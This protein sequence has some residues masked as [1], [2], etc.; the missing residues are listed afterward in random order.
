MLTNMAWLLAGLLLLVLGAEFFVRGSAGLARRLGLSELFIGLTIVAFG[1]SSPELLVSAQAA[2]EG[3]PGI[4]LG[5]IVGS[6]IFNILAILGISGLI[7]PLA[8]HYRLIR[9]DGPILAVASLSIAAAMYWLGVSRGLGLVLVLLLLAYTA[10]HLWWDKHEGTRAAEILP[11]SQDAEKKGHSLWLDSILCL[12]GLSALVIGSQWLVK[13]AES[14]AIA[15]GVPEAIIGLTIVAAG[16]SLPELASSIVAALRGKV[17]IAVGNIVGSNLFNLLGILGVT[18]LIAPV[19]YGVLSGFDI[20]FM[21]G[22]SL[23]LLPVMLT[24]H[25]ISRPEASIFLGL[26]VLYLYALWP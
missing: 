11:N 19:P 2:L 7:C 24:H 21:L 25:R 18:A 20:I 10:L 3:Q 5:N 12:F 23:L 8:V 14:I 15:L 9:I 4:A 16:T 6:N 26:Y 13:G 22:S 1:T 17:D